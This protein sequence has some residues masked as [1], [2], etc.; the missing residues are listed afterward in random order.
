[1]PALA[2]P[3]PEVPQEMILRIAQGIEDPMAV[4]RHYGFDDAQY[5]ALQGWKPFVDAVAAQTAE[6]ETSG[7]VFRTKARY[8]ASDLLE[9]AYKRAASD[10][11]TLPQ[12]L[13]TAK[14]FVDVGDLKPNKNAQTGVGE[15]FS[16]TIVNQNPDK[17]VTISANPYP[18]AGASD[19]EDRDSRS[20]VLPIDL[21]AIDSEGYD[22]ED[23]PVVLEP[24]EEKPKT[25]TVQHIVLRPEGHR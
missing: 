17:T 3:L 18:G 19:D 1:M 20:L 8:L 5:E 11:A 12:L 14:L 4:A 13:E 21:D 23:D 16:I 9:R 6:L 10:E 22:I 7:W 2:Y 24:E 25:R 15:G